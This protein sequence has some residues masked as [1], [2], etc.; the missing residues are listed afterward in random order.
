MLTIDYVTKWVEVRAFKTN[1]AIVTTK[2][3]CPLTI[4]I[5]QGVHFINDTIKHLTKQFMLKHV[6]FTTYYPHGNGQVK[7]T[8]KV[9]NRLLNI[10]LQFCFHTLLQKWGAIY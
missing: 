6:S 4:I 1:I 8:N 2:F 10:Y 9:I 3:G 7:S 5:N